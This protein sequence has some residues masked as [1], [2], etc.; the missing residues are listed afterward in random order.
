[1]AMQAAGAADGIDALWSR[2]LTC[3]RWAASLRSC[4]IGK[5]LFN[6]QEESDQLTKIFKGLWHSLT[7]ADVA[8]RLQAAAVRTP[9]CVSHAEFCQ[10]HVQR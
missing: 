9:C 1:M 5:T 7:E 6:G 3:G 4:C 2:R 8:W 10:R